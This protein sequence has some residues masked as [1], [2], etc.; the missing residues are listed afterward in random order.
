MSAPAGGWAEAMAPAADWLFDWRPIA[1]MPEEAP[2]IA[3][4]GRRLIA[5][6]RHGDRFLAH[7]HSAT[8]P[9]VSFE[10]WTPADPAAFERR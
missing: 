3:R 7:P 6:W 8:M 4:I 10:S 5:G 2:A 9:L 1:A